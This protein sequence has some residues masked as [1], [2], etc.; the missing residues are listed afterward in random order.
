MSGGHDRRTHERGRV[1]APPGRGAWKNIVWGA[2]FPLWG[3]FFYVCRMSLHSLHV[4]AIFFMWGG[5][6][7]FCM[8]GGGIFGLAPHSKFWRSPLLSH[9]LLH[10]YLLLVANN[11]C[12]SPFLHYYHYPLKNHP[13]PQNNSYTFKKIITIPWLPEKQYTILPCAN[14]TLYLMIRELLRRAILVT[15]LIS[16]HTLVIYRV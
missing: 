10:R 4:G 2:S 8:G 13:P 5:G 6:V 14:K 15:S 12:Q 9:F 11:L 16:L 7:S 1:D 3:H